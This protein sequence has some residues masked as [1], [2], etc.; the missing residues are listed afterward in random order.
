MTPQRKRKLKKLAGLMKQQNQSSLP[1]TEPLLALLDWAITPQETDFLLTMGT[2]PM[3]YEQA[4]RSAPAA[5]E[6]FDTFF[7]TLLRK[8]MVWPVDFDSEANGY[9]LAPML[10]GWFE[11]QLCG[12]EETAE[13]REFARRLEHGFQSW[14]KFNVFP[15]RLLQN[16]FFLRRDT[17]SQRIAAFTPSAASEKTRTIAVHRTLKPPVDSIYPAGDV[18]ELIERYSG[19]NDIALMHCFCRQWRKMVDDPC[20]FDYPP[21]SC[22]AIGSATAHIVRYGFGRF[23]RKEEALAVIE[24]TRR[25]GAVHTLFYEKDD[26]RRPEIG[27][28][29]CCPDCCGLLGS[30]NRGVFPLMFKSTFR[31]V[32]ADSDSCTGCGEC[33]SYCPVQAIELPAGRAVVDGQHCIGCGQCSYRCPEN[34]LRLERDERLVKLPLKKVSASRYNAANRP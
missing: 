33:E 29:N 26:P 9:E 15:L 21:E 30:H 4:L 25:A 5:V 10:V 6:K 18:R 34:V 19:E 7:D 20:R 14:K 23:V 16:R 27:I 2:A 3:T 11:L 8:G 28:C 24:Q 22:I 1:V 13:K 32:V 12:G 31:A 17:A